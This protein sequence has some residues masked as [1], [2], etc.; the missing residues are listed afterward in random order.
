[1][2]DKSRQIGKSNALTD[3]ERDVGM[4]QTIRCNVRSVLDAGVVGGVQ[5]LRRQGFARG[6]GILMAQQQIR[7]LASLARSE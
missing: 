6:R 7:L 2:T 1:M 4:P 3:E 5:Q